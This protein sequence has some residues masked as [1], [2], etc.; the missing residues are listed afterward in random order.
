MEHRIF[1]AVWP[2]G[3]KLGK[4]AGSIARGRHRVVSVRNLGLPLQDATICVMATVATTS[5][6]IEFVS[7]VVGGLIAAII[8]PSTAGVL[9]LLATLFFAFFR[10]LKP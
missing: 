2:G 9:L 1:S 10:L 5:K 8:F 3:A 7:T 4:A 6:V